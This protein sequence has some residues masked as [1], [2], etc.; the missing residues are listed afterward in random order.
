MSESRIIYTPRPEMRGGYPCRKKLLGMMIFLSVAVVLGGAVYL[1][2]LPELQIREIRISGNNTLVAGDLEAAVAAK[3]SGEYLFLLPKRSIF[4]V[5]GGEIEEYL[6][7]KFPKIKEVDAERKFPREI[8][9]NLEERE[10]WGIFCSG[11]NEARCVYIDETGFSYAGAP[12]SS[13]SLLR[14]VKS[15]DLIG[16]EVGVSILE[17]SRVEL[18]DELAR[19]VEQTI[20]SGATGYYLFSALPREIRL[21]TNEGFQIFFETGGDWENTFQVLKRVFEEEIKDKRSKIEYVDLRFGNKVF[22]R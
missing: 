20:G 16:P 2:R 7:L 18:L 13:G 11:P 17:K 6:R 14:K 3:L 4:L 19:R 21:E 22:Y 1:L 5:S 15:D 10:F 12:E 9:V 8:L